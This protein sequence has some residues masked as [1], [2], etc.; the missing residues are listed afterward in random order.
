MTKFCLRL[1]LSLFHCML[2][3]YGTWHSPAGPWKRLHSQ[4]HLL[5][6]HTCT[7]AMLPVTTKMYH[8]RTQCS[9]NSFKHDGS[10]WN[11]YIIRQLLLTLPFR[12]D[13]QSTGCCRWLSDTIVGNTFKFWIISAGFDWFYSQHRTMRHFHSHVPSAV[14][15]NPFAS[16]TPVYL[17]S[18][19]ARGFTEE[20]CNSIFYDPLVLGCHG[21]SW[22]I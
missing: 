17:W 3:F 2:L 4:K 11:G 18:R 7:V 5:N 21:N 9:L 8:A 13:I 15:T 14:A 22:C 19:I 6:L 16:F 20:T 1:I 12:V 10:P